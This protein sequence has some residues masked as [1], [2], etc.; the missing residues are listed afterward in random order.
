MALGLTVSDNLDGTASLV[1]TGTLAAAWSVYA[2]SL[3]GVAGTLT[4][5][6]QASGTGDGSTTA[7]PTFG[8]GP[9]LW[10]L[11]SGTAETEPFY[12]PIGRTGYSP[13]IMAARFI[14]EGIK[15]LGLLDIATDDILLR[16]LPRALGK[17]FDRRMVIVSPFP[18]EIDQKK[19]S[20]R[21]DIVYP[22]TVVFYAPNDSDMNKDFD[23]DFMNRWRVSRAFRNQRP[24]GMTGAQP[25]QIAWRPD[26]PTSPAG[27][28]QRANAGVLVFECGF[29]ETRGVV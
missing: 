26:L 25:L 4:G 18:T 12:M 24:Q 11:R 27:V 22:V 29:R 14:W 1:I 3:T 10:Q 20:G 5:V 6:L 13:H 8:G 28:N 9:L 23:A 16:R 7:T 21:D 17:E 19:W 2:Y 15:T